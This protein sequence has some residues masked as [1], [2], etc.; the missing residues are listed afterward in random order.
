MADQIRGDKLISKVLN[1]TRNGAVTHDVFCCLIDSVVT[2]QQ[3]FPEKFL[4]ENIYCLQCNA[5]TRAFTV[6]VTFLHKENGVN[7]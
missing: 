6:N 2:R 5:L 3:I 7:V 1:M 4:I